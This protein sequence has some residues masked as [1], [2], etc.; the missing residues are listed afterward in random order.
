MY[1]PCDRFALFLRVTT[2]QEAHLVKDQTRSHRQ[3]SDKTHQDGGSFEWKVLRRAV[4]R[5]D[6]PEVG[7]NIGHGN[8]ST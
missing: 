6:K 2:Q 4:V 3:S 5:H 7:Q 1:Q 8:L